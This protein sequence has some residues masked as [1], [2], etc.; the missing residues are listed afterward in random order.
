MFINATVNDGIHTNDGVMIENGTLVINAVDE[1]INVD[2]GSF[3]MTG[4]SVTVTTSG[5]SAKGIKSYTAM[6]IDGGTINSTHVDTVV[7]DSNF[8]FTDIKDRYV[9][10]LKGLVVATIPAITY[11]GL[12]NITIDRVELIVDII[13]TKNHLVDAMNPFYTFVNNNAEI[14]LHND[15]IEPTEKDTSL[16]IAECDVMRSFDYQANITNRLRISFTA[17]T[18]LPIACGDTMGIWNALNEPTDAVISQLRNEVTA[19]EDEV[20]AL[21]QRDEE[22]QSEIDNLNGQ[23]TLNTNNIA[24][25]TAKVATLESANAAKD[26][27]LAEIIERLEALERVPLAL[28]AYK[29]NVEFIRSQIT[30]KGYGE[31]YQATKNFTASGNFMTDVTLG[32]LVPVAAD[33]QDISALSERIEEVATVATEANSTAET[34]SETV[35]DMITTVSDI[36]DTVDTHTTAITGLNNTMLALNDEM[37]D[38]GD[39][40]ESLTDRVVLLEHPLD[41]TKIN[42]RKASDSTVKTY[43][44]MTAAVAYINADTATDTEKYDIII[45]SDMTSSVDN[46][47]QKI[48]SSKL[49]DVYNNGVNRVIPQDAFS[50]SGIEHFYWGDMSNHTDA[51]LGAT[52]FSGCKNLKTFEF[53]SIPVTVGSSVFINSGLTTIDIPSNVTFNSDHSQFGGAQDL[54]TV[55]YNSKYINVGL[56]CGTAIESITIGPNV[57]TIYQQA[58]AGAYKLKS[59]SLGK[60]IETVY[61]QAFSGCSALESATIDISGAIYEYAF[62]PCKSLT[63]VTLGNAVTGIGA[64]AFTSTAFTTID[65]PTSVTSISNTAFT[66]SAVETINI[67][68]AENSIYGSPWGA[69]NATVNWLGE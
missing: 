38:M 1:G 29:E 66:D 67:D 52:C 23:V 17:F 40:L 49:R 43:D 5:T 41:P 31:L 55:T 21:H 62:S 20:T 48:S 63:N 36:S 60:N 54:K 12:Y 26:T 45:G 51:S 37:D 27:L 57:T 7:N 8:H 34:V 30:W 11:Q 44:T 25:L 2:E 33:A 35:D 69:T 65:I 46:A 53:P 19:L 61:N 15:I 3:T 68:K 42:V 28:V 58:F 14:V 56:F 47:Y 22:L 18:S 39:E 24:T 59:I 64:N 6:T 9:Q 16:T 13:D 32:N 50:N 4:G 10:S